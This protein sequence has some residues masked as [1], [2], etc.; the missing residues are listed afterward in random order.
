MIFKSVYYDC[1]YFIGLGLK[2]GGFGTVDA[3]GE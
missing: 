3:R 2:A 1:E